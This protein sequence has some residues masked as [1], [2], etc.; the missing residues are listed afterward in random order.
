MKSEVTEI[1]ETIKKF[2]DERNWEQFHDAKN[3]AFCLNLESAEL[4]QIFLWK[5]TED[6]VIE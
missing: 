2:R 3:L 1:L 5:N 4:L 6:A